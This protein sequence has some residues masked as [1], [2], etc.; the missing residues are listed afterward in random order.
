MRNPP[1]PIIANVSTTYQT[2]LQQFGVL[3]SYTQLASLLKRSPDG[4]RISLSRPR[5][6]WAQRINATKVRF[7]RR[8]LFDTA[9]IAA[10]IDQQRGQR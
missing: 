5:D 9:A 4:L 1:I 8:V 3:L 2:L 7:G 6:E 10:L